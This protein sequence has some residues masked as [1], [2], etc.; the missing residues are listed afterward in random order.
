MCHTFTTMFAL[1]LRCIYI[2]HIYRHVYEASKYACALIIEAFIIYKQENFQNS[3][4]VLECGHFFH[5]HLQISC[6]DLEVN[7]TSSI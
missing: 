6:V 3:Y 7:C 5:S 1:H 2:I 4:L